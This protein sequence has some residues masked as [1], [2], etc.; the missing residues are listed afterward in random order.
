MSQ[1][2]RLSQKIMLK[3]V[4]VVVLATLPAAQAFLSPS[5][6]FLSLSLRPSAV[7]V[8]QVERTR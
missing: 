2:L 6:S 1:N 3:I 5:C 8:I 7:A 4:S